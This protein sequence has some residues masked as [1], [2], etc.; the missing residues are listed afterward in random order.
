[1]AMKLT[2]ELDREVDGRWIA[3]VPELNVLLYGDSR[4]SAILQAQSAA[5]EIVLDRIA[6]GKLPNGALV[7]SVLSNGGLQRTVEA[8]GGQIIRTP[9][10]DKNILEAML[11]NGAGLGGEKSGHVI[12]LEHTS[13]G[14]GIVTALEVMAVM[15]RTGRSLADLATQV[16]MLPQQQRTIPARHKDQ[17]EGDPV[18]HGAIAR[19][20]SRLGSSGRVL[21][22]PSGTETA[23][24]VMVEGSDEALV[25]QLA[26]ELAVLAGERLN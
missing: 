2:I 14:D 17:W 21:V 3:E 20:E 26:D 7:V 13:S 5:R 8:A 23:I 18:L 19:A 12:I 24:R 15:T 9:V 22:R 6:H 11:V 10:G 4:Q 25:T 16:P 1:M